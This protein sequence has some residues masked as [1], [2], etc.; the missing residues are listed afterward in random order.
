MI[1]FFPSNSDVWT[2]LSK[3]PKRL[4]LFSIIF[5]SD[6]IACSFLDASNFDVSASKTK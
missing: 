2:L 5:L 4:T 6:L 1:L 3:T